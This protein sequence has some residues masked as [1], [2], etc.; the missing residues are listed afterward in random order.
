MLELIF[1]ILYSWEPAYLKGHLLSC[2]PTQSLH[3]A[4]EALALDA[5]TFRGHGGGNSGESLL[6]HGT[7][8]VE[9]PSLF[10]SIMVFLQQ[11]K[12]FLLCLAFP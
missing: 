8:P 6:D 5:P 7:K 12:T 10:L 4:S 3:L 9:L 11:V 2:E 1:K